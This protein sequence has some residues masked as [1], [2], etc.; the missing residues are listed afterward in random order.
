MLNIQG[1][2]PSSHSRS[3]HKLQSLKEDYVNSE[4]PFISICESWLK[5]H[6]TNAQINIPNY[7]IVRQDRDKRHRGGVLLYVHNSLPTSNI[8]SFDDGFCGAVMCYIKSINAVVASIYRPPGAP[9]SSFENLLKFIQRNITDIS[10]NQCDIFL[11]GDFNLPNMRWQ[12]SAQIP[13]KPSVNASESLLTHFIED[14]FLSQYV[15]K[16]TRRNNTLDIFLTNNSNIVLQCDS[17]NTSLSDHNIVEIKTTYNIKT[18]H[19]SET[20]PIP[21][22]S[23]RSIN[24]HKADFKKIS[25]HIK[26]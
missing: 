1:M 9:I 7:Q 17:C 14:N 3:K 4:V 16:P 15:D 8:C 26:S 5:H 6:I 25:D 18:T 20:P 2:D 13:E 11:M 22:F 24:L 23:F 12:H 21:E 10:N 19:D